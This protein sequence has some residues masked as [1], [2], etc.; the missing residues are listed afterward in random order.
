[1]NSKEALLTVLDH[2]DYTRNSCKAMEMV[3]A[4]LPKEVIDLAR[5]AIEEESKQDVAPVIKDKILVVTENGNLNVYSRSNKISSIE[6]LEII[7][8]TEKEEIDPKIL[9]IQF[10]GGKRISYLQSEVEFDIHTNGGYF[11]TGKHPNTRILLRGCDCRDPGAIPDAQLL[12]TRVQ[13]LHI[14]ANIRTYPF[15]HTNIEITDTFHDKTKISG[16]DICA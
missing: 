16:S 9:F 2:V 15:I 10:L 6:E 3:G 8:S 13:K 14:V 11:I 1:M 7:L 4:V 5:D 12:L